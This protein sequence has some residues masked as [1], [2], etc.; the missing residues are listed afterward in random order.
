MAELSVFILTYNERLHIERCIRAA[1]RVAR[2]VF[3]VDSGSDDGTCELARELGAIVVHH[4]WDNNHGRQTNWA[5]DHLPF[6]TEWV[7][8]IDSDEIM[9]PELAE[10]LEC[11]LPLL[12]TDVTGLVVKRRQVF[13]GHRLRWG[14]NYPILLLRAFRRG[15]ARCEERWMDEHLVVT[16]GV[17]RSLEHDLEDCNLNELKWWTNKQANYAVREAADIFLARERGEMRDARNGSSQPS[18]RWLK[19]RFYKELPPFVR[20]SLYFG[21]RYFVRFGFLDGVPGL[22]WHVL[23][24]FWYRFLVDSIVYETEL[25]A[26]ASGARPLDVLAEIHR[27]K[28]SPAVQSEE[29]TSLGASND[30]SASL[31]HQPDARTRAGLRT[32]TS[33]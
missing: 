11:T 21:Y 14:G 24:G 23:Q 12:P 13:L 30:Q 22:V 8:R 20:P 28:A 15:F 18:A 25:R 1:Q 33:P 3:V 17:T 6:D 10:E 5:I 32:I 31:G 2:A 29:W 16:S 19:K 26:K 4:S 7:M 27:L 9:T